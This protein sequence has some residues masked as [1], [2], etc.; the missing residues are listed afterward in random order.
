MVHNSPTGIVHHC[1]HDFL[2]MALAGLPR[3]NANGTDDD[4]DDDADDDDGTDNDDGNNDDDDNDDIPDTFMNVAC[5]STLSA[6]DA[7]G[8]GGDDDDDDD[9]TPPWLR[10][11]PRAGDFAGLASCERFT[12]CA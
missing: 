5:N 7:D 2:T 6:T 12:T 3:T 8:G 11:P 4:D 1:A 9:D 10:S